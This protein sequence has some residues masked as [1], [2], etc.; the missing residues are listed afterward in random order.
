MSQWGLFPEP[1]EGPIQ[2]HMAPML[3]D[4]RFPLRHSKNEFCQCGPQEFWIDE[5]CVMIHR[6]D[7]RS[8]HQP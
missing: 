1:E 3:P 7:E 5:V 4:G 8:E 6:D 2:Y